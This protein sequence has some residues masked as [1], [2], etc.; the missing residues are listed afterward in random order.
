SHLAAGAT[1]VFYQTGPAPT[2]GGAGDDD[3]GPKGVVHAFDLEKRKDAV[4]IAGIGAYDLS[5]D[6]AKLIYAAGPQYG[7][8]DSKPGAAPAK[9]G[10]GALKLDAMSMR[11][12]PPAEWRQ[13]FDEAWRLE[14]DFFYVPNMHGLDWPAMKA[15]YGAL[16]PY[17]GHRDSL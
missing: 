16:L 1:T 4:V 10:D 5:A 2:L 12:D 7:I 13:I 11:L 9:P 14:R 15:K 17:V 6:G 3:G 8:V